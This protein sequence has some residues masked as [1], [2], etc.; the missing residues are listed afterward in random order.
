[1]NHSAAAMQKIEPWVES[2]FA[3]GSLCCEVALGSFDTKLFFFTQALYSGYGE[4]QFSEQKFHERTYNNLC[5]F[6][7]CLQH[8]VMSLTN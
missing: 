1:M 5:S 8:V 4:F 7:R 6:S 2:D 3:S